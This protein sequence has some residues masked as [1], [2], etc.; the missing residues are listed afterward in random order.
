MNTGDWQ[1]WVGWGRYLPG[2][3]VA[4][5]LGS[6]GIHDVLLALDALLPSLDLLDVFLAL[7][8]T[9]LLVPLPEHFAVRPDLQAWTP[10]CRTLTT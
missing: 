7:V 1:E 5:H 6:N 8:L 10:L 3:P 2:V 9:Q 4:V